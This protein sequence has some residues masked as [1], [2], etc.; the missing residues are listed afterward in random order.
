MVRGDSEDPIVHFTVIAVTADE[1]LFTP[2]KVS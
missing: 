2:I 1:S